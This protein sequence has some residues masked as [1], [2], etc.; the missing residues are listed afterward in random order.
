M[1]TSDPSMK[2]IAVFIPVYNNQQGLIKSLE[3]LRGQIAFEHVFVVD[4]GSQPPI[5][6]PQDYPLN[7]VRLP[8]NQGVVFARNTGLQIIID[9]KYQFIA[10][11]DAGDI[12]LA[13]RLQK[14]KDFLNCHKSV[15]VVGGAVSFVNMNG[16]HLFY[17]RPPLHDRDI[18]R[19]MYVNCPFANPSVMIRISALIDVGGYKP[20]FQ[21]AEDYEIFMRILSKYGGANLEDVVLKYEINPNGISLSKRKKLLKVRWK[22]QCAYFKFWSF[23]AWFGILKTFFLMMIPNQWV[24]WIKRL[25]GQ[26]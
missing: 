25:K 3:S 24:L 6:I 21:Y 26:V 4:D 16:S 20:E 8:N 11:L 18:R 13:F 2:D 7:L 15:A 1:T 9:S 23:W 12:C 5:V 14:Q 22:V 19:M 17:F 10:L